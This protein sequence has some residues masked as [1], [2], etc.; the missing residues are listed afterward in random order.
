[1]DSWDCTRLTKIRQLLD[2]SEIATES[3][4]LKQNQRLMAEWLPGRLPIV[5]IDVL[6]FRNIGVM[7]LPHLGRSPSFFAQT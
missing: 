1:M 5:R 2:S 3:E 4:G 7:F 6:D